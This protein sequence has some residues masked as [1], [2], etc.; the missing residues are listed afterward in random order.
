VSAP[1]D[2]ALADYNGDGKLDLGLLDFRGKAQLLDGMLPFS[3]VNHDFA[4]QG[5]VD[6][7]FCALAP[8]SVPGVC[9]GGSLG[10][11]VAL[12][13]S[14]A[15]VE[16][17]VASTLND[18]SSVILDLDGDGLNEVLQQ[19]SN[20]TPRM[21]HPTSCAVRVLHGPPRQP[22]L[23]TDT[24]LG[25][26]GGTAMLIDLPPFDRRLDLVMSGA[27]YVQHADFTF[28]PAPPGIMPV[29]YDDQR[30]RADLS[31]LS[32]IATVDFNGDN[33]S[34]VLLLSS[35]DGQAH[36]AFADVLAK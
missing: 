14:G 25:C 28:A 30:A 22:L 8:G 4:L 31:Q 35:Q 34:D 16:Q 24:S 33:L 15:F 21:I 17:R 7:N 29:I 1:T 2:V 10:S 20:A 19:L 23:A 6:A 9:G 32:W 5:Q 12:W 3:V 36:I 11:L 13:S 27:A 26:A 18:R